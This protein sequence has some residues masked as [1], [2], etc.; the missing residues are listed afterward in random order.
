[1]DPVGYALIVA[2]LA[3]LT[4][5]LGGVDNGQISSKNVAV[6][7]ETRVQ[8][9]CSSPSEKCPPGFQ[10]GGL[11]AVEDGMLPSAPGDTPSER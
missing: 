5:F 1:M 8:V 11:H 10:P 7:V 3:G 6:E 4:V 2:L 9:D